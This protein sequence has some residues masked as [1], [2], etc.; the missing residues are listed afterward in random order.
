MERYDFI[1]KTGRGKNTTLD[2]EYI[3]LIDNVI[4]T[5]NEENEGR[6]EVYNLIIGEFFKLDNG[7]FFEEIKYRVTDLENPNDVLLDILSRY[8]VDELNAFIWFLKKRIEEFAEDD[9]YERFF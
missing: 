9:F 2:N 1:V 4:Q 3:R 5:C 6:W 7:K 8:N